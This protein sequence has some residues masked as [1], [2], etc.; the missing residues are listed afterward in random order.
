MTKAIEHKLPGDTRYPIILVHGLFGFDSI[1]GFPYW[2][3]IP[4]A[5][6]G[7]G[8]T[9]YVAEVSPSHS[10]EMR[11]EQLLAQLER[12]AG[13]GAGKVNLIG[14][15]QGALTARYVAGKKPELV[16]SV[17][18][19]SGPN[20]GS[21]VADRIREKLA[22]G[23]GREAFTSNLVSNYLAI[24]RHLNS[25]S[26]QELDPVAALDALTTAGM[27]RFN[28]EF[29]YGLPDTWGGEGPEC[30]ENGVYYYSWSG[31]IRPG[32]TTEGPNL[33][34]PLHGLCLALSRHFLREA[35]ANDG[36]VG[37]YSSHLGKVIR[38]DYHLDHFDTV[39]QLA[40]MTPK[41]TDPVALYVEH[42][43]RL[44]ERGL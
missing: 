5:L 21:E 28:A 32:L 19:V 11:G 20:H 3:K 38:S 22:P 44:K 18:S 26:E 13:A 16:A 34:D 10:N 33:L 25:K 6:Q 24:T 43:Q 1:K 7:A 8:A 23:C 29:P 36:L 40:G 27:A 12:I 31:A 41:A 9:V 39:N 17:T 15:S 37:R 14:H 4:E 2:Y 42:A 35:E 30:A